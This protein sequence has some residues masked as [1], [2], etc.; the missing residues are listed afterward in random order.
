[1]RTTISRQVVKRC[2][3]VGEWDVGTLTV[4]LEGEA[5]ELH[6]LG[7]K[8]DDLGAEPLTHEEYTKRLAYVMPD[9]ATVTT[10]WNTGPWIVEVMA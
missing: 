3:Y 7:F 1:M 2:P 4:V 9:G 10:T 5:P 8:I 6:A